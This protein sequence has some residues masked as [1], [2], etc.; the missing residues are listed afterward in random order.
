MPSPEKLGHFVGEGLVLLPLLL[1][2]IK[3]ASLMWRP[4]THKLCVAALLVVLT[5]WLLFAAGATLSAEL[6]VSQSPQSAVPVLFGTLFGFLFFIL[7]MVLGIVGLALYDRNRFRQGRRQAVWAI[8]MS[9]LPL[10]V[11]MVS[12]CIAAIQAAKEK[13]PG[14]AATGDAR[15]IKI[16][17]FNFSLTPSKHWVDLKPAT[18]NKVACLALR[19]TNPQ[20]FCMVIAERIGVPIELDQLR[21]IAK[22]NLASAANVLQQS[23]ET[24]VLNGMTFARIHTK[25]RPDGSNTTLEYEH[26]LATRKG[27]SWQIVFWSTEA[28]R[29]ALSQEAQSLMATF[30]VLDPA[31]DGAGKGTLADVERPEYGYHTRLEGMG[32]SSWKTSNGNALIDFRAQRANEAL[33]VLPL[34]FT[35]KPPDQAALTRGLL[36]ALEFHTTQESEFEIKPWTPR[37]GATQ[38]Q[39]LMADDALLYLPDGGRLTGQELQIEREVNGNRYHYLLRVARGRNCAYLTAGW[40]LVGKGD[41]DL[42][43]HSL[44][45]ILFDAL[46]GE[47]PVLSPER[48]K[49]LG[50]VLNEA[51]LSLL[52]R[53]EYEQA[54]GCFVKGF[55]QAND[56][57]MLGNAG[58]ALERAK[59]AAA[60][61]D[62]LAPFMDRFPNHFYLGLRFARLQALTGDVEGAGVSF[63]RLIEHGL[64]DED[65]LLS[66]LTLLT[67]LEQYPL[68]LRSAEAWVAQHPSTTARR[69]QAETFAASG[70]TPKAIGLLEKLREDDPK[71]DHVALD[72]GRY[73]ND[74]DEPAKAASIAEKFLQD[75]K[76][77]PKALL[78]LGWSQMGRKWYRDAK[79]TFERAAVKLPDDPDVQDAIRRAS[80]ELGQGDNSDVKQAIEPVAMPAE[81]QSSLAANT[82]APDFGAGYPAAWLLRATGYQWEKGKPLRRTIY[83]R[84]KV[85]TAEGAKDFSSVEATFDPLSERIFMNRLEVKDA[86]GKTVAQASLHDSY[87]QDLDGGSASHNKVLHMQVAG[88]QPGTSVEWVVTIENRAITGSAGFHRHLLANGLPVAA[89]AVFVTGEVAAFHAELAQGEGLKRIHAARLDAWISP[90]LAA[91]PVE[92]ADVRAEQHC[93]VLWLGGHDASWEQV[94]AAYL[95]DLTD[96][97]QADES[98]ARLAASLVAGKT[99]ERLRIAAIAAYV[100]KEIGYKAIEF[101]VRA[102]R[103]NSAADTLR[104]RYGDC[105]DTALLTHLLLQAAGITSHLALVNTRWNVQP[106]LPDLDQFNHMVVQVPALGKNWLLD[107]TDKSLALTEFPAD[108]LWHARA[109]VLDPAGP[110]LLPPPAPPT[111]ASS[112]VDSR[113]TVTV[114]GRDWRVE[115]TLTL[116]G[117]YAAWMRDA[118]TGCSPT[119]QRQKAQ[120][121]LERQG[122]VQVHAF[123][124]VNLDDPGEPA[125]M[126]LSYALRDGINHENGR[127]SGSLPALWERDFLGTRFVK[128]RKT[129]FESV[130]PLHFTSEVVVQLPT[131]AAAAGMPSLTRHSQSEFCSWS[132]KSE[133]HGKEILL[134]FDFVA[135]PGVHPAARYEAFHESRDEVRRVWDKSLAWPAK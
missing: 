36:S 67:R 108:R 69:W 3:C 117:Y 29:A 99:T 58:D 82:P 119:E 51:G 23:E 49:A 120:E 42:V 22:S 109:L 6:P 8:V 92:Y 5:A 37:P 89:E 79:A 94:G 135:R 70:D 31:L 19:R 4:T 53:K 124:F 103:P 54:A 68:A 43:R 105:K 85:L 83:R 39:R 129:P 95:H 45:L 15:T 93:P 46:Q 9:A 104:L 65:D 90:P 128:D 73:Y 75:G 87:V 121:L 132:L 50:M 77:V 24:Q 71:D 130:Y 113:R 111:A 41:L 116:T 26:W 27:F 59:K 74:A 1:G 18:V 16:E 76:E 110:R 32:W 64:K 91:V 115:E 2:I 34:R 131:P 35:S 106:A 126:E 40:A 14:N 114:D 107:A 102:R 101:G 44:D 11:M 57:T 7:A 122:A 47:P 55:E 56:P 28:E 78:I 84:V 98:V 127:D 38:R 88:V 30:R 86:A 112:H 12:G 123:R 25:A 63:L 48:K 80:A 81:V 72:L 62:L 33:I 20:V 10:V 13:N 21:E 133:T 66:W 60:G 134:N 96:R 100:Q 61:R 118:F 17:G 52:I 125:R 97:L